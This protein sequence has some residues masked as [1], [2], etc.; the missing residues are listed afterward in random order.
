[1]KT[2]A[3]LHQMLAAATNE[4]TKTLLYHAIGATCEY[5]ARRDRLA[6]A[7]DQCRR[8][9]IDAAR[10]MDRGYRPNSLGILQG[11]GVAVDRLCGELDCVH[12]AAEA[13]QELL[14]IA[15]IN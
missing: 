14:G 1:M 2:I 7:I 13:A 11:N 10:E 15:G 4:Q 8:T 3:E 9:L 6:E 12:R 5:E